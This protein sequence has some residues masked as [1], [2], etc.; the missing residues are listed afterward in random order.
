MFALVAFALG[1][2]C[3]FVAFSDGGRGGKRLSSL[4][5]HLEAI[6]GPEVPVGDG[7]IAG[8][9]RTQNGE[10]VAGMRVWAEVEVEWPFPCERVDPLEGEDLEHGVTNAVR[11]YLWLR[12]TR[13]TTETDASGRFVLRGMADRDYAVYAHKRGYAVEDAYPGMQF[14]D[15]YGTSARPGDELEF[16]AIPVVRLPVE[17]HADGLAP[18]DRVDIEWSRLDWSRLDWDREDDSSFETWSTLEPWIELPPGR[19]ELRAVAEF[20]SLSGGSD[21][22]SVTL[23]LGKDPDPI[24]FEVRMLSTLQVR[25]EKPPELM[26]TELKVAL[27]RIGDEELAGVDMGLGQFIWRELEPGTYRVSGNWVFGSEAAGTTT[28]VVGPG[29]TEAVLEMAAPDPAKRF[30]LR[31]LGPDGRPLDDLQFNQTFTPEPGQEIESAL[32]P[33]TTKNGTHYLYRI[34]NERRAGTYRVDVSHD[35]YGDVSVI[36]DPAST[37]TNEVRFAAPAFVDATVPGHARAGGDC[38]LQ[39]FRDYDTSMGW[40]VERLGKDG[41]LRFGPVQPGAYILILRLESDTANA[42]LGNERVVLKSGE[43]PVTV[44]LPELHTVRVFW[45]GTGK[46]EVR[47]TTLS[48]APHIRSNE[49]TAEVGSDGVAELRLVPAGRYAITTTRG[50]SAEIEV[51]TQLEATLR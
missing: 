31:V 17:I 36:L 15:G 51:P 50:G 38:V 23:R 48:D 6:E 34:D 46:A 40:E 27:F 13:R 2:V 16:S 19:Y 9:V 47:L 29:L 32:D 1:L 14:T 33:V 42:Y 28:V 39:F 37:A 18:G 25:V 5:A 12:E 45:E 35:D 43:Q 22:K 24:A 10:P 8:I 3:G 26:D 21:T 30:V 4:R 7:T 44:R 20:D 49:W 41:Q 11:Q